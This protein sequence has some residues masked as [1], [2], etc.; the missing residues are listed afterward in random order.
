MDSYL[1]RILLPLILSAISVIASLLERDMVLRRDKRCLRVIVFGSLM[2]VGT[3]LF[4]CP[5][6][7]E[8]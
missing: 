4:F 8:V 7:G 2:F 1:I 5:V 3:R 6:W